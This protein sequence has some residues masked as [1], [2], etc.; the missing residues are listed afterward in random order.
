MLGLLRNQ[1]GAR[2]QRLSRHWRTVRAVTTW[3]H[4]LGLLGVTYLF[5]CWGMVVFERR[6]SYQPDPQR[7]PPEVVRLTGVTERWPRCRTAPACWD[8]IKPCRRQPNTP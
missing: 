3:R 5:A 1:S 6:F 7:T 4:V 2:W 8:G